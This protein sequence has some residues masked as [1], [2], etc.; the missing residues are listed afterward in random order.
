[1]SPS[2]PASVADQQETIV[3]FA[4]RERL[5]KEDIVSLLVALG[6]QRQGS[7]E[8]VAE[9]LLSIRGL[10]ARDVLSKLSENDLRVIV[11]RFGVP[12]AEKP[13]SLLG[14]GKSL[15]SDARSELLE[16]VQAAAGKERPPRAKG[17][18]T[19]PAT[20]AA[21]P[22]IAP[23][24]EPTKPVVKP[25]KA[26]PPAETPRAPSPPVSVT[27]SVTPAMADGSATLPSFESVN[28][29][30]QNYNFPYTWES[31]SHYEAELLGALRAVYGEGNVSRQQ[32]ESGKRYDLMV[33]G[34]ARL[35][36]KLPSAKAELDRME[37]QVQRYMD[38]GGLRVIVVI[39]QHEY[40]NRQDIFDSRSRLQQRGATVHIK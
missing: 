8:E 32:A 21:P 15:F 34:A 35:E 36:L 6:G 37:T 11:R 24:P 20:A 5:T 2:K 3:E 33:K 4:V 17:G 7:R 30:V 25:P 38:S 40:K 16:R 10:K 13:S 31:E 27:V 23:E 12:E 9:R 29:F 14:L 39:L 18:A 26:Q 19:T 22:P 28:A 1:M